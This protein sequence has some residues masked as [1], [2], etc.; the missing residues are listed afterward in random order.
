MVTEEEYKN[1]YKENERLIDNP[2][3]NKNKYTDKQL[4]TKYKNY[5]EKFNEDGLTKDQVLRE[6]VLERD[7]NTC[8][9]WKVLTPKEKGECSLPMPLG[10]DVAHIFPKGRYPNLRYDMDN[11][12]LLFRAFHNRLDEGKNPLNGKMATKEEIEAWWIRLIGK[13][14]YEE[15]KELAKE[16]IKDGKTL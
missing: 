3:K 6:K 2:I 5:L 16:E 10:C 9:L 15:L 11:T 13:E 12:V 7:N 14:K 1:F 8:R 4:T